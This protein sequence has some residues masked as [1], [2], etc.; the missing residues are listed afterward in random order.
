MLITRSIAQAILRSISHPRHGRY[1]LE[2]GYLKLLDRTTG[3]Y[4]PVIL[5]N[6]VLS[7]VEEA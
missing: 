3:T 7:T 4:R 2:D 6:R 5:Q 1:R